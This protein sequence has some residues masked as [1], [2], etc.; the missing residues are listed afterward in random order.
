[1]VLGKLRVLLQSG[2]FLKYRGSDLPEHSFMHTSPS[3]Q[4]SR[5]P[6]RIAPGSA[7]ARRPASLELVY[8][9]VYV[10]S[11]GVA[12]VV[13]LSAPV[14]YIWRTGQNTLDRPVGVVYAA[15]L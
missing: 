5:T 4:T 15:D 8:Y 11:L 1:M 12:R 2:S 14:P 7:P 13:A 3:P 6:G 9:Y 10:H